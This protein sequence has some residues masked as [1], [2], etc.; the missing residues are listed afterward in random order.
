MCGQSAKSRLGKVSPKN[1]M[2]RQ[3]S[4]KNLMTGQVFMN[5]IVCFMQPESLLASTKP[6]WE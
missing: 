2:P 5:F 4:A 1:V 3:K 6:I